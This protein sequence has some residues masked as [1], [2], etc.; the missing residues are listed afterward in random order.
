MPRHYTVSLPSDKR[1]L[2][3]LRAFVAS[4]L[5]DVPC[6]DPEQLVLAVDEACSNVI[7]YRSES[8]ETGQIHVS[9]EVA[10]DLLRF[11]IGRFCQSQDIPKIKPRDLCDVRPGGLGTS[12]IAQIMDRV[13][14][15]EEQD[16]PGCVALLLEKKVAGR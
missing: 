12:F 10:D 11:R 13:D 14:Y 4:I 8:I 5:T 1:S 16:S 9:V 15:V 6:D 7:K 2:K 3:S